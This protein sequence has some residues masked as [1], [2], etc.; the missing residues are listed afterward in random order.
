MESGTGKHD[1]LIAKKG[2]RVN[3]IDFS[4]DINKTPMSSNE[5]INIIYIIPKVYLNILTPYINSIETFK[6]NKFR[7]T[8]FSKYIPND[9]NNISDTFLNNINYFTLPT[10]KQ[11]RFYFRK[12]DKIYNLIIFYLEKWILLW[13]IHRRITN[14]KKNVIIATDPLS[15]FIAAKLSK[16]KYFV[17][18]PQELLHSDDISSYKEKIWKNI[19]RKYNKYA[20]LNVSFDIQRALLLEKD[21]GIFKSKSI[22]IP[23][24]LPGVAKKRRSTYLRDKFKIPSEKKI[25]LY[26]GGLANY[27]LTLETIRSTVDWPE[28]AVLVMHFWGSKEE[29]LV[30]KE[31]IQKTGCEIYLST[32]ILPFHEIELI[33]QSAD[34]GLAL[35]G[36]MTINHKYA[37]FSSGKMFNFLHNAV[38]VITNSTNLLLENIK[39]KKCGECIVTV[40]EIGN[41][42][43]KIILEED[44]YIIGCINS[45]YSFEFGSHHKSLENAIKD[46]FNS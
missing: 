37:G 36:G 28:C 39:E 15:L 35:Y 34:V 30:I 16:N 29:I 32:E 25:V 27:N 11:K 31:E 38:P 4:K 43:D 12:L 45:Y 42:I 8:V 5:S 3:G 21:N 40:S 22:I 6:N 24:S 13:V 9:Q 23:N 33:Y 10:L 2:Y 20:K 44:K 18:F 19:E 26:T 14:E 41:A 17:Y 7:V 1:E 46:C